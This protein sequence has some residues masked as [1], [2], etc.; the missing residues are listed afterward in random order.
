[1]KNHRPILLL[2]CM[3]Y[4]APLLARGGSCPPS[5]AKVYP[6]ITEECV[7][8]KT[9]A[10]L[11]A[12]PPSALRVIAVCNLRTWINS[13]MGLVQKPIDLAVT[14]ISLNN[15]DTEGNVP[16][17][18]IYFT[19]TMTIEG[20]LEY[21]PGPAGEYWF[22]PSQRVVSQSSPL[23]SDLLARFKFRDES[24][25]QK[26]P[27]PRRLVKGGCF[28]ANATIEMNGLSLVIGDSD[29]AGAYPVTFRVIRSS[30]FRSCRR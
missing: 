10:N 24:P 12:T 8:G 27:A 15:Y 5:V 14:R 2:L 11:V 9:L 22:T 21:D 20:V 26:L 6:D 3:L 19:G 23:L 7:C 1:M 30:G 18:E 13:D 28:A 4:G 17:G 16:Y 29:E 25:L